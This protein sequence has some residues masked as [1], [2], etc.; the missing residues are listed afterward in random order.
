MKWPPAW[1]ESSM[2]EILK[3]TPVN[4]LFLGKEE[5]MGPVAGR[6]QASGIQ[7][8]TSGIP[9]SGVKLLEGEWP[10]VKLSESGAVDV[11]AAGPT[12]DPWIDSN[13]WNIRLNA[14]FH[15]ATE[16]WVS[17]APKAPFPKESYL[18][19]VAEAAVHNGRWIIQLDDDLAAAIAAQKPEALE[20]WKKITG[21]AAFFAQRAS[22]SDYVPEAVLGILS[23]FAGNNETL[24]REILNLVA[25]TNQ[26]YRIL[27]KEK[28]TAP[29]LLG[30][31]A[32]LV[33]DADPP[34]VALRNRILEFV[35]A[36]GMLITGPGWGPL[37][38]AAAAG[39]VM[40]SYA[41]SNLG[42]GR[43]ALHRTEFD[44][45]YLVAN[46][47]AVLISHRHDLLRFFNGGAV[48]SLY[49]KRPDGK[50]AVVQLLFYASMRGGNPIS[51]G[52]VGKFKTGRLWTLDR[53]E[54]QDLESL[55]RDNGLEF[56]LPR[57][58]QYAAIELE[59]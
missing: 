54:A 48:G 43:I 33:P 27:L 44:D 59:A 30:L 15:P 32:V 36:G 20:T 46:D 1:K 12:G 26:Q 28:A 21:A 10:G 25:R 19:T 17:A 13:G 34:P 58:A 18:I 49:T 56:H 9:P 4:F 40:R 38:A 23:D 2:L 41:I 37:P 35:T 16:I 3:G 39:G 8:S 14:E 50:R 29:F 22:W 55:T 45:P 5:S 53:S 11:T 24:G 52:V 47:C 7:V 6:A 42:K 51:V 31:K 57:V